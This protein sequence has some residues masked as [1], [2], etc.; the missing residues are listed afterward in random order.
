MT[1]I[2]KLATKYG[3]RFSSVSGLLTTEQLWALPLRHNTKPS[4]D[5]VAIGISRELKASVEES[6]VIASSAES[7]LLSL[8]LD[9]VKAVIAERVEEA[10]AKTKQIERSQELA[11][12]REVIAQKKGEA[13]LSTDLADLEKRLAELGG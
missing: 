13:L 7:S 1:D 5:A 6:F 8:K 4:L 12:I 9:V 2:F 10:A 11:R 3:L